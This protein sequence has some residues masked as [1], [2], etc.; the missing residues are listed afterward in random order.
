[1]TQNPEECSEDFD[2]PSGFYSLFIWFLASILYLSDFWLLF[3]IYLISGF[4]SLFIWPVT[5]DTWKENSIFL[6]SNDF[7][8]FHVGNYEYN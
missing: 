6:C 2:W 7:A 4:Y 3:F 5:S 1:M 8:R